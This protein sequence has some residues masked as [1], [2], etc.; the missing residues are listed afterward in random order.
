MVR[1]P[2]GWVE[3]DEFWPILANLGQ[4]HGASTVLDCEQWNAQDSRRRGTRSNVSPLNRSSYVQVVFCSSVAGVRSHLKNNSFVEV[5]AEDKILLQVD[6]LMIIVQFRRSTI[7]PIPWRKAPSQR[8]TTVF[9]FLQHRRRGIGQRGT[10][11]PGRLRERVTRPLHEVLNPTP[12][13][14]L[15]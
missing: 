13:G 15:V 4:V 5:R 3:I 14:A 6:S 12:V 7:V 9:E 8:R 10:G 1:N 11:F 2:L